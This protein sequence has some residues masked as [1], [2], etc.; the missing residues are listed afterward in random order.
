MVLSSPTSGARITV[1]TVKGAANIA[2]IRGAANLSYIRA[3]A[4]IGLD[5]NRL[6]QILADSVTL[7]DS[8]TV[9]SLFS[10]TLADIITPTD[11]SVLRLAK[12]ITD[13][14]TVTDSIAFNITYVRNFDSYAYAEDTTKWIDEG[15]PINTMLLNGSSIGGYA[16]LIKNINVKLNKNPTDSVTL[17]DY[18][19]LHRTY[20]SSPADSATSSDVLTSSITEV[21]A[22]SVAAVDDFAIHETKNHAL[23]TSATATDSVSVSLLSGYAMNGSATVLN[24][25]VLN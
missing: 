11:L 17:S 2:Y 24:T 13:S 16:R 3:H 5:F 10:R 12:V 8:A 15:H 1:S 22:D 14:V 21:L 9:S 19:N 23:V 20:T 7:S 25:N 6:T 18:I 4:N